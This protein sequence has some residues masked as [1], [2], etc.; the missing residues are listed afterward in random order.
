MYAEKLKQFENVENLGGK[1]WEHAIA[2]DV[3]SQTPVKD[4]SLHCF[5]YQ[6]MFE[7]LFKHLLET[8]TKYG[9]YPR[10]HKLDKLLLQVIDDAGFNPESSKYIDTLNAITVCVEA[11]R[12]NFLL[13]CKTYQRSVEILNPLFDELTEFASN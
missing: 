1:A 7:L 6:Q 8:R 12:Y 2:C 9:A 3:I 11:Y 13:D 4:C 10:T 5:H